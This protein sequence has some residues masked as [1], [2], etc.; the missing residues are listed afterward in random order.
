MKTWEQR[1][2]FDWKFYEFEIHSSR[3]AQDSSNHLVCTQT[4]RRVNSP[5]SKKRFSQAV[6]RSLPAI[7][8]TKWA[9]KKKRIRQ[10]L[11]ALRHGLLTTKL[12]QTIVQ[13]NIVKNW[14]TW[15]PHRRDDH[16]GIWY[17]IN[18]IPYLGWS[19]ETV[20]IPSNWYIVPHDQLCIVMQQMKQI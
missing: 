6:G 4:R 5:N 9:K 13:S 2:W 10:R 12:I 7:F 8:V 20:P 15:L 1:G 11:T 17:P 19:Q 14:M 18:S 3:F 16:H